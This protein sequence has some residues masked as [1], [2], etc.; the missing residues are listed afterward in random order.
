MKH[1]CNIQGDVVGSKQPKC[2]SI[3]RQEETGSP[4][5]VA[6]VEGALFFVQRASLLVSS[7]CNTRHTQ[8]CNREDFKFE[9]N[10]ISV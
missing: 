8:S 9:I 10:V 2:D 4:K 6:Q 7:I 1:V 5:A 3:G